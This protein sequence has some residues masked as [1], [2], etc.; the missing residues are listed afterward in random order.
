MAEIISGTEISA[1]KR[2][3]IKEKVFKYRE[4]GGHIGLAVIIVG[5]DGA[6]RLYGGS[7]RSAWEEVWV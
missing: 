7:E 4:N 2:R 3:E 1:K 6:S 5:D